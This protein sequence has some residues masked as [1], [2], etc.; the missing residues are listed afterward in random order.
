[1]TTTITGTAGDDKFVVPVG[2]AEI[3]GLAGNDEFV[4]DLAAA[5]GPLTLDGGAGVDLVSLPSIQR[6]SGD[7]IKVT[8][9]LA[10][11]EVSTLDRGVAHSFF[12]TL[13]SIESLVSGFAWTSTFIG[14]GGD[15]YLNGDIVVG[16]AGNDT[17]DGRTADFSSTLGG[18]NAS[19][20][21]DI[22]RSVDGVD[23]LLVANI[24]GSAF[25]DTLEGSAFGGV[26]T[27]GAGDDLL[28][29]SVLDASLASFPTTASYANAPGPVVVSLLTGRSS[30]AAGNDTLQGISG[31]VG[32]AFDDLLIG[33]VVGNS[34]YGG[35]GNDTLSGG[36]GNDS[37]DGGLG[38][39]VI[40]GG[41]GFDVISFQ[42]NDEPVRVSL[43]TGLVFAGRYGSDTV[44]GIE[45]VAGTA[46]ADFIEGDNGDNV[47]DGFGCADTLLGGDGNDRLDGGALLDGGNG[48]DSLHAAALHGTS[49]AMATLIGG[50]GNDLL[51]IGR[52]SC[53]K[54]CIPPCRSR[55]SPYH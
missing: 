1:M 43:A 24:I 45:N 9:N 19:L 14:D 32:G 41:G 2:D 48:N 8:I 55:W 5:L 4:L 18:V 26:L 23:A 51:E 15:N 49:T 54:E 22:A 29:A 28:K 40:D 21:D 44:S 42:S 46:F 33:S 35:A 16:G 3:Q 36:A 20:K 10:T 50:P 47:I 31:L 12:V 39:D 53:R 25:N 7:Y 17:L 30:G 13:R 6:Q 27:G 37:L 38:N 52:A 34:L 11:G